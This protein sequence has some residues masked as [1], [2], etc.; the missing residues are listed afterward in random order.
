M[1][2]TYDPNDAESSATFGFDVTFGSS[3]VDPIAVALNLDVSGF[4]THPLLS[5][6]EISVDAGGDRRALAVL[7]FERSW[8]T[9]RDE[10]IFRIAFG[11]GDRRHLSLRV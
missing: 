9:R 11:A 4:F 7:G 3:G 8:T 2:G 10:A 5:S 1:D 6:V